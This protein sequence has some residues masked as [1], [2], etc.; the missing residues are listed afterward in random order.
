[1]DSLYTLD[2]EFMRNVVYLFSLLIANITLAQV[3]DCGR[4]S[5]KGVLRESV[6]KPG[7]FEYVVLEETQSALKFL[8]TSEAD[9]G[10][11]MPFKDK[12]TTIEA[13]VLKKL[14]GTKGEINKILKIDM[15]LAN[16]LSKNHSGISL[17][18]KENCLK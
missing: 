12:T 6:Q 4:Y 5:M 11:I 2:V 16:P 18:E 14:D 8:V 1:M 15:R 9:L 10:L 7:V 17:V 13:S 3:T